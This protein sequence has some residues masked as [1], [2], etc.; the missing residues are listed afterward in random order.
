[1]SEHGHA[2]VSSDPADGDTFTC[3]HCGI[4]MEYVV[5]DDGLPGE[6]VTTHETSETPPTP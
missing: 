4:V 2:L 3:P 6:W 5:L 1:M